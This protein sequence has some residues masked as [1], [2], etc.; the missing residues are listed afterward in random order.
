[1]LHITSSNPYA[2]S[3]KSKPSPPH[4]ADKDTER[5]K[6]VCP[7]HTA[8]VGEPHMS[9]RSQTS[10][11]TPQSHHHVSATISQVLALF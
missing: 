4:F 2:I 9:P 6:V 5:K 1:M 3:E 7:R 8:G 11:T 10:V